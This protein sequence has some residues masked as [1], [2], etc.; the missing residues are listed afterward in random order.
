VNEERNTDIQDRA[1]L[2]DKH[3]T[4]K[5]KRKTI[6]IRR[7]FP[8]KKKKKRRRIKCSPDHRRSTPHMSREVPQRS[9]AGNGSERKK[10]E[11]ETSERALRG[12]RSAATKKTSL[13]RVLPICLSSAMASGPQAMTLQV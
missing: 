3:K 4:Q 2:T 6:D 7:N 10:R 5:K 13:V 8:N 9:D 12:E 1:E 11:R